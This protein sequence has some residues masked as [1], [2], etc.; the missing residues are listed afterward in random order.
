MKNTEPK[1]GEIVI[2]QTPDK[3]IKID[4]SLENE[5]IWLTQ[6]Q[7]AK[8]FGK[9]VPD[10]N[11]HIKNI[12]KHKELEKNA[13]IRKFRIVQKEG[14]RTVERHID[15]YN[16]DMI[17]SVGYKVSSK[18]A[19]QFR[20]WATKTLKDYL[21]KGYAINEKRLLEAKSKF[22][23]LKSTVDFLQKKV[24]HEL[25]TGQEKEILSLLADYSKTMPQ[26]PTLC[27]PC[28]TQPN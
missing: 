17:I 18:R 28:S 25:V 21:L 19:T 20:I 3:K 22:E 16:L 10:V 6:K 1:K 2:Y 13:T 7:I 24:G 14:K 27:P 12:Y 15:F 23:E 11:E 9:G 4:V 8:L 5:T 26:L